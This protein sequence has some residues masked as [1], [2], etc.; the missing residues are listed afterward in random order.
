MQQLYEYL[1]IIGWVWA[2]I[3]LPVVGILLW[4]KSRRT[5]NG[6]EVVEDRSSAKQS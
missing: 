5:P 1:A 3:A 2:V 6:F 4:R